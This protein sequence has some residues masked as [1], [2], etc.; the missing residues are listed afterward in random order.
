MLQ[1]LFRRGGFLL[2]LTFIG[3]YGWMALRGPQGVQAL[4]EKHRQIRQLQEQNAA[5]ALDND[6]R[7]EHI[8]LLKESP[9]EQDMEIRKQLKL[10][11]PGETTFILPDAPKKDPAS[12]DQ[13]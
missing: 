11:R 1:R 10:L 5:M 4:E 9:S 12:G 6:R 3:A 13:Q 2:A 8:R 7:R